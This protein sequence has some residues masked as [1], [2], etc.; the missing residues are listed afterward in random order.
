MKLLLLLPHGRPLLL[1]LL[2]VRC[3]YIGGKPACRRR[4]PGV[5]GLRLPESLIASSRLW[6]AKFRRPRCL[7]RHFER[8]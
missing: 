4:P 6:A 8:L 3:H 7:S 1:L 5:Q 2:L